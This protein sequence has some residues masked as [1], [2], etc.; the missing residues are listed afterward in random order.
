MNGA[1]QDSEKRPHRTPSGPVSDL[2]NDIVVA[3]SGRQHLQHR[4]RGTC[5][6]YRDATQASDLVHD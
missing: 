5:R 4:L 6:G 3:Q 2:L 1:K